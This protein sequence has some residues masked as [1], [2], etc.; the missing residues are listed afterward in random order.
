MVGPCQSWRRSRRIASAPRVDRASSRAAGRHLSV[1]ARRVYA[2]EHGA[3]AALLRVF[4]A[5]ES[6]DLVNSHFHYQ[7]HGRQKSRQVAAGES[8]NLAG[9][10]GLEPATSGVT[11]R[12]ANRLN[13]DPRAARTRCSRWR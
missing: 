7:V 8:L 10:T 12:R 9:P 13:H 5:M 1:C 2:V 3:S 6:A 11:G 4:R